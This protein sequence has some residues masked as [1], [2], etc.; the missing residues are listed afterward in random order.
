MR[1]NFKKQRVISNDIILIHKINVYNMTMASIEEMV[2]IYKK[3]LP[4]K[5]GKLNI[6]NVIILVNDEFFISDIKLIY[7]HDYNSFKEE[8][9]DYLNKAQQR[10]FKIHELINIL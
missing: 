10:K 7:P 6:L 2:A 1:N 9:Y 8:T 3:S 5:H 4:N